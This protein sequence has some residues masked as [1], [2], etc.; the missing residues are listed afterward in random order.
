MTIVRAEAEET[1]AFDAGPANM[2]LDETVRVLTQGAQGFDRDGS[3]AAG[4]RV[5]ENLLQRLLAHPYLHLPIPKTTGRETFGMDFVLPLLR[6]KGNLRGADVLATLTA[7]VAQALRH[8]FDEYVAPRA[9]PAELIVSGGGVHNLTLMSHLRRLFPKLQVRP[10][11]ELGIDPDAKEAMIFAVLANETL[12]GLPN[13]LP[14]ATGARWPT[15]MGKVC[16]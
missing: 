9:Q 3:M 15:V 6:G 13:N 5:D 2:P 16:P 10:L 12:Q 14:G 1:F 11:S 8:A 7:F 4:G